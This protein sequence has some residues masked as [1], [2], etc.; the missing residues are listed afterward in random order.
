LISLPSAFAAAREKARDHRIAAARQT[1]Y[2]KFV[3]AAQAFSR[4]WKTNSSPLPS[5]VPLGN[6]V[7]SGYL[8]SEDA[9]E[10]NGLEVIISLTTVTPEENKV[11]EA[12]VRVRL[13]GGRD[14]VLAGDGSVFVTRAK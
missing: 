9:R 7:S 6:L 1:H 4:D 14:I 12:L 5:A 3:D 11:T 8:R 10:F 13:P 2:E